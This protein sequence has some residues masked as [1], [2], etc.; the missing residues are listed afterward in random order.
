GKVIPAMWYQTWCASGAS[1]RPILQATQRRQRL[2]R[3]R[4]LRSTSRELPEQSLRLGAA[5]A[6]QRLDSPQ[7][8]QDLSRGRA[9]GDRVEQ[10]FHALA[11]FR[12][13]RLGKRLA[14]PRYDALA[15]VFQLARRLVARG[16][17]RAVKVRQQPGQLL[18][19]ERGNGAQAF[20]QKHGALLR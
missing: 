4:G 11:H 20:A 5:D 10:L 19:I 3:Q 8:P 12:R 2:A 7:R 1:W 14:Q 9:G 6:L 16:E 18:R 13:R 17:L 15:G